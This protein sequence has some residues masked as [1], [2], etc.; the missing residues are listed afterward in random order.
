MFKALIP[1]VAG[2]LAI[3]SF[4]MLTAQECGCG[5]VQ[6][7]ALVCEQEEEYSETRSWP[8]EQRYLARQRWQYDHF[9][10]R[11]Y[12]ETGWPG[13]RGDELSDQLSR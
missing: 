1:C 13:R 9:L 7:E 12:E 10:E 6:E 11:Q 3:G 8:A 2:V 5:A 4:A